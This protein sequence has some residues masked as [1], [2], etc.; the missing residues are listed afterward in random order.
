MLQ[1][2]KGI[3]IKRLEQLSGKNAYEEYNTNDASPGDAAFF[4][5]EF[6]LEWEHNG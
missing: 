1:N 6:Q 5:F 2:R 4:T 3:Q